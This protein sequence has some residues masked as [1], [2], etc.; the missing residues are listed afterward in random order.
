[1]SLH[2]QRQVMLLR[3]STSPIPAFCL[4]VAALSTSSRFHLGTYICREDRVVEEKQEE[5]E[6][7]EEEEEETNEEDGG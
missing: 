1:M 6:D 3:P 5:E 7:E 4:P 2:K